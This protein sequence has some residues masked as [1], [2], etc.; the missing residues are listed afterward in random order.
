MKKYLVLFLILSSAVHA[1]VF[2]AGGTA[3][4][5]PVSVGQPAVFRSRTEIGTST[6]LV[7]SNGTLYVEGSPLVTS[8]GLA[9]KLDASEFTSFTN[10]IGAQAYGSVYLHENETAVPLVNTEYREVTI[11]NTTLVD[12]QAAALNTVALTNGIQV[13]VSGTYLVNYQISF[14][15]VNSGAVESSITVNGAHQAHAEFDRKLGTGGDIGSAGAHGLLHL[16][17]D[18]VVNVAG[19]VIGNYEGNYVPRQAQLVVTK[20]GMTA[21]DVTLAS[22]SVTNSMLNFVATA[23]GTNYVYQEFYDATNNVKRFIRTP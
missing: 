7:V 21:V 1:N 13:L 12:D 2:P 9:T 19:Q 5:Q 16:E 23:G 4:R 20:V 14:S 3:V 10:G 6:S 15:G 18:D 11:W 8:E 22:I 17:A